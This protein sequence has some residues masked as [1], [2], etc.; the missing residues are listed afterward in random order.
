MAQLKVSHKK[1]P[2]V[3][4]NLLLL[5]IIL[6][7]LITE[8]TTDFFYPSACLCVPAGSPHTYTHTFNKCRGLP[9]ISV[10]VFLICPPTEEEEEA[11][12]HHHRFFSINVTPASKSY[13][14]L[15]VPQIPEQ[16]PCSG[17]LH[18]RH[19]VH[20]QLV[21]EASQRGKENFHGFMIQRKE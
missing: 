13:S 17:H 5:I 9:S 11:F 18:P 20:Q 16:L 1:R 8:Q 3:Q 12:S 4:L 10:C 6:I 7:Q 14:N 15:A 2:I 19:T 21:T